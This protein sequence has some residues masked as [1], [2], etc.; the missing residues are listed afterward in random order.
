MNSNTDKLSIIVVGASGDL[1]RKKI[2]PALFALFCQG[3]L[4]E[5]FN[6]F[7]FARSDYN[8]ESFRGLIEERLTCRYVPDESSCSKRMS[9][10][11]ARC[12][13]TSGRYDS[14][15]SF[16]DL[17]GVM[18]GI[19]GGGRVNRMFYLAV[20]PFVFLDT[21]RAIGGAGFVN[22]RAGD[23]WSRVVIEKPFGR[24]RVSSDNLTTELAKVFAEEQTYRI[25]HYLG[26]E[27]VQNLMVLRFAN[28]IFE[29]VWNCD[30]IDKICIN[31]KE[32]EG[33]GGRGGY[34]D[35]YGIIRDV[36]QNHLLQILALIAMEKPRS[37]KAVCVTDE[38]VE[39]LRSIIPAA[40][41]DVSVAQ[42]VAG[43][44]YG[45]VRHA[46]YTEEDSV[47]AGSLTPTYARAVLRVDN[48]RW[49]GVPF[50]IT[51]GKG[52][53]TRV[54]EVRVHFK[55]VPENIFC[56]A[57][58]CLPGNQLVVRIQPDEAIYLKV[59][60]KKPGLAVT[61]METDLNLRYQSAFASTIPDAYECLLLDV[62]EGD[63]GLFIRSDELGA[64]W[65]V[66]TPVLNEMESKSIKP[67]HYVFGS[68]EPNCG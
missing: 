29:P 2:Y 57:P 51:A 6:I 21:V 38:K 30:Y 58:G 15:D 3:F 13:Y 24:D 48:E 60:N 17:F 5:N 68:A 43:E 42:Y 33:V 56:D 31:W 10:F 14:R 44:R 45:G 27:V 53:D 65:D 37:A 66:F 36:M 63:K 39:V 32:D 8:N 1:A 28:L 52:L 50:I 4:P 61:L 25:D 49:D 20:P 23:P 22:C 34:F 54:N 62:I 7:G 11:L 40:M 19:E 35:G 64:A 59:M 16:L 67:A 46:G 26:K 47:A 12:F 41:K 18:R 55:Q 9:E